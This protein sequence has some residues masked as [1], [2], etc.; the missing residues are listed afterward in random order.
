MLTGLMIFSI[1]FQFTL[2]PV[3]FLAGLLLLGTV[4]VTGHFLRFS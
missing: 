2:T 3:G 4:T 1:K